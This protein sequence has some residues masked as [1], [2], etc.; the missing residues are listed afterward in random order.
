MIYVNFTSPHEIDHLMVI[1]DVEFYD[2][3]NMALCTLAVTTHIYGIQFAPFSQ[4]AFYESGKI[5]YLRIP[6]QMEIPI[7]CDVEDRICF[8]DHGITH[9]KT[10]N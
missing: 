1:G 6:R 2:S 8:S 3:G 4:L 9:T 7:R 5:S 10:I